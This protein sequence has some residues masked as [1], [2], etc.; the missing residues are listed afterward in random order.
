M[1]YHLEGRLL[2]YQNK[3]DLSIL[4]GSHQ[5][6]TCAR[7]LLDAVFLYFAVESSESDLHQT[8]RFRLV[9]CGIL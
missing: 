6:D 1:V 2:P 4:E 5:Y 8:R 9:A 3:R 7:L